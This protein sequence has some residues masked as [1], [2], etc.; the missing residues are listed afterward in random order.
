[1]ALTAGVAAPTSPNVHEIAQQINR[2]ARVV[3]LDRD[4]VVLAHAR[5]LL[6]NDRTIAVPGDIRGPLGILADPAI[7]AHLDFDRPLGLLLVAVAHFLTEPDKPTQIIAAFRDALAQGSNLVRSHVAD[8]EARERS[9]STPDPTR[10]AATRGAARLYESLAGQQIT[11]RTT[12]EIEALFDGFELI[13]PGVV[14]AHQWRLERSR[15]P[16]Q[17]PILA[18]V[19]QIPDGPR[20]AW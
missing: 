9:T 2:G 7:R 20:R 6:A 10:A 5:A 14:P 13:P 18:G 12:A 11:L 1:M 3:H 8:L 17:V 16:R 15:P 19:G 4:P